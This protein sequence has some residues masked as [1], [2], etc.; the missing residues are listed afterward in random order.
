[1]AQKTVQMFA[2]FRKIEFVS[3]ADRILGC[4]FFIMKPTTY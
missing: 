3:N 4:D 2:Y 1:M